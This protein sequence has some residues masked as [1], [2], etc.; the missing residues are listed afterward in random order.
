MNISEF[1]DLVK[2]KG[3]KGV[4]FN[5]GSI[6]KGD[7]YSLKTKGGNYTTAIFNPEDILTKSQLT[8]IYNQAVGK[9]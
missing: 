6:L 5:E 9:K 4:R 3:F 7:R 1:G 2:Q 8:D